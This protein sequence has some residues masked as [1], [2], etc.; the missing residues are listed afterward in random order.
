MD[1][2]VTVSRY[3]PA[4]AGREMYHRSGNILVFPK[5]LLSEVQ[6]PAVAPESALISGSPNCVVLLEGE[7]EQ[8]CA[9][10]FVNSCTVS[11]EGK[12]FKSGKQYCPGGCAPEWRMV[13]LSFPLQQAAALL[14]QAPG[15][16]GGWVEGRCKSVTMVQ[17]RREGWCF[18][19]G[20][21]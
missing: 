19:S 14:R 11:A 9:L 18:V 6:V 2:S 17:R 5:T 8:W 20:H 15:A 21:V 4:E 16:D 13:P 7:E 10:C 3:M 12:V 1:S